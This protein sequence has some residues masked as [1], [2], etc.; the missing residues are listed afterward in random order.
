MNIGI[1]T[2]DLLVLAV[3]AVHLHLEYRI[4]IK[5]EADVFAKYRSEKTEPMAGAKWAY[6]TKALW[7][8]LLILMQYF[9]LAFR[10][11][12]PL[13]FLVYAVVLQIA[14][15]FK[16][17]NLLNLVLALICVVPVVLRWF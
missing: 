4:W 1:S 12:L 3:V 13:S 16:V 5:K 17:Y 6:Y 2:I 8:L 7:L 15:P 14:L 9:G 11:A 10:D